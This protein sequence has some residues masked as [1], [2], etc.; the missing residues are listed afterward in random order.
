MDWNW[1]AIEAISAVVASVCVII[2]IIFL[3]LELRH[4]AK[5]IE[6]T[7]IQSL[8]SLEQEV[9]ALLAANADLFTRGCQ[10]VSVLSPA[11][12]FQFERII[13]AQLS[14]T[15]SAYVQHRRGLMDQEVWDAYLNAIKRYIAS[16]GFVEIWE[17]IKNNYPTSFRRHIGR[18]I[19]GTAIPKT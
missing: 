15:Y 7:T 18:H 2:S 19:D 13:G 17:T 6:G 8:M 4:N 5:A 14:L 1:A 11:E 12:Q 9:F 3:V 10:D 16:P